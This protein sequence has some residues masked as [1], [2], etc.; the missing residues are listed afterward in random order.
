M[1]LADHLAARD[2]AELVAALPHH[3]ERADVW[4]LLHGMPRAA[5]RKAVEG[6]EGAGR[7]WLG[8]AEAQNGPTGL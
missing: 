2:M 1:T 3:A 8:A 6:D 4:H 5:P 7:G